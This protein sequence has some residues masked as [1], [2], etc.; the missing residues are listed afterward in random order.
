MP[1]SVI[2][3]GEYFYV[4][5]DKTGKVGSNKFKSKDNA[6]KQKRN[7]ERFIK[8]IKGQTK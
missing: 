8:M 4:K 1:F 3:R 2:K 6:L 5:N 7:R